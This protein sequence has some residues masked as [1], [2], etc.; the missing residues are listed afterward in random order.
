MRF[1]RL[2]RREGKGWRRKK[3]AI[4]RW[5]EADPAMLLPATERNLARLLETLSERDQRRAR[6]YIDRI[7]P[8]CRAI[9]VV[10]QAAMHS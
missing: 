7:S 8:A 6:R 1:P 9:K 4:R 10:P 2:A 3:A 5:L